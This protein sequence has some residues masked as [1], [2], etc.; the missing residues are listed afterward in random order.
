MVLIGIHASHEQIGPGRLL[1]DMRRAEAAGFAAAMCSDHF[2]PWSRE[3]GHSGFA[4]SWLGAALADTG[5]RFGTVTAPGQRYHPA[6]I[7]QASATLAD[8]FPGRFWMALGSGENINESITGDAWPDKETRQRRL[9]EC[10][11]AIRS[12]HEGKTV[13][14]DGLVRLSGAKVWDRPA[15]R[16]PLL[17]AVV[18]PQTARRS[19]AWADGII[20]VNQPEPALRDVLDAYRSAG[21]RGP[22][23]L[24]VHLSWAA[25]QAEAEELALRQWRNATVSPPHAWDLA[26]TEEFEQHSAGAAVD[27][28]TEAVLVSADPARHIEWLT[29][30]ARLGFEEIYLH[31]VG[32]ELGPFIDCFGREVLP[33]VEARDGKE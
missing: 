4:W 26:T 27:D 21:G 24:Q 7:A 33:F 17:A 15:E 30:F 11:Q 23:V 29:G 28:V 10:A 14:H 31:H 12:L 19:A 2:N 3:Q 1:A 6:V 25:T 18:S 20:T 13:D 16:P 5:L 32:Q 9:E 22:A 8:M